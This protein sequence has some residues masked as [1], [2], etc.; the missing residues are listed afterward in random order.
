MLMIKK[1]KLTEKE[2]NIILFLKID[3][4]S[5]SISELQDKVW[6]YSLLI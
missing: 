3:D 1:L 6:G 4:R 2:V 5:K